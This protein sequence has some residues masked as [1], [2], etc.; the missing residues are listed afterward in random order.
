MRELQLPPKRAAS[1]FF[2]LILSSQQFHQ[3]IEALEQRTSYH[4]R[5]H[6]QSEFSSHNYVEFRIILEGC[7][8]FYAHVCTLNHPWHIIVGS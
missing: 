5:P 1:P 7:A 6:R 2:K 4:S 3:R 8:H